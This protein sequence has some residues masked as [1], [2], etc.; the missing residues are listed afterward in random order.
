MTEHISDDI[1]LL[2]EAD[3]DGLIT[4]AQARELAQ[5]AAAD[6]AIATALADARLA[7]QFMATQTDLPVPEG[8]ADRVMAALPERAV[9]EAAARTSS[10]ARH[11]AVRPARPT[12]SRWTLG[13]GFAAIA[14]CVLVV[15]MV[16]APGT[17]PDGIQ[18]TMI[19]PDRALTTGSEDVSISIRQVADEIVVHVIS[20]RSEP[21]Q[22]AFDPSWTSTPVP[23][24]I[25]AAGATDEYRL[26]VRPSD[27]GSL[28]LTGTTPDGEVLF[29][30]ELQVQP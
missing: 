4:E 2:I 11:Y 19:T 14:A 24:E 17:N 5:A 21:V 12:R 10:D 30:N 1:A 25:V 15:V 23:V 18:A 8:F 16:I 9:W 29:R 13:L 6:P 7:E 3:V 27:S 28:I 22:L 20:G 26:P